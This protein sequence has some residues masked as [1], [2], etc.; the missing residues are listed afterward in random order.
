MNYEFLVGVF[1]LV[2]LGLCIFFFDY[3]AYKS[4]RRA[5]QESMNIFFNSLSS[6]CSCMFDLFLEDMK[7]KEFNKNGQ[8]D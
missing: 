3:L 1:V 2:S 5:F 7:S 4:D 6:E 8:N